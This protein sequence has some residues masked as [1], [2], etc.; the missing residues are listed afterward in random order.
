ML[1]KPATSSLG[2]IHNVHHTFNFVFYCEAVHSSSSQVGVGVC[3]VGPVWLLS[4]RASL[5]LVGPDS[6]SSGS[7]SAA[8]PGICSHNTYRIAQCLTV[9]ITALKRYS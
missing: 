4:G 9:H 6:Q 3:S 5:V 1:P 7:G 8:S 2:A